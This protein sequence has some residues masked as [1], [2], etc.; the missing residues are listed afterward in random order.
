MRSLLRSRY[1][2]ESGLHYKRF[3]YCDPQIGRYINEDSID[4]KVGL[5]LFL[6]VDRDSVI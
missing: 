4:L 6:R 5:N 3:R 1:D 2:R